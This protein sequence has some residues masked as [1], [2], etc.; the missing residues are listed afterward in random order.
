MAL[1]DRKHVP[2]LPRDPLSILP[3]EL[4]YDIIRRSSVETLGRLAQV[5]KLFYEIVTP[6]LYEKD[7]DDETPRAIIWA[8]SA[9]TTQ[10]T[11]KTIIKILDLA[12][13]YGGDVDCMHSYGEA[14]SYKAAPLHLATARGNIAGAQKLLELGANVNALGRAFSR[15][16][17]PGFQGRA[18]AHD[19]GTINILHMLSAN[20]SAKT[21]YDAK[22]SYFERFAA[23]ID[24][25]IQQGSTPLFLAL[26]QRNGKALQMLIANG[27]NVEALNQFGRTLLTQA[28]AFRFTSKDAQARQWYNNVTEHLIKSGKAKVGNDGP[29]GAWETPLTCTI[30]AISQIA[31]EH[32]IATEDVTAMIDLL[33]E[34]G[35][36]VNERSDEG[37]T[38]F[39]AL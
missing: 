30:K 14:P 32:K 29:Q 34:H 24:V 38:I 16:E 6:I 3:A 10:A 11:E 21:T 19:P 39:H 5:S 22:Q 26:R 28:I 15:P 18:A 33:L 27:A 25:P 13:E 12:K 23:L 2:W 8:A 31:E 9:D 36:D 17:S 7:A 35:A 37:I 20:P 4:M 1:L